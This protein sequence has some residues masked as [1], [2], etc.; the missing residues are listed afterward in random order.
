[1]TRK[2]LA[3]EA[4]STS[5][6]LSSHP[7]LSLSS[8]TWG[9]GRGRPAAHLPVLTHQALPLPLLPG[10]LLGLQLYH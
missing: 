1:M 5:S 8:L 6:Q 7:S 4:G 10:L 9:W 2:G 3:S